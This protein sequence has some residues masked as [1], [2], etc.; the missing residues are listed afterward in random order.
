[1]SRG[2]EN[3]IRPSRNSN[4]NRYEQVKSEFLDYKSLR[5]EEHKRQLLDLNIYGPVRNDSKLFT[6]NWTEEKF[7]LSFDNIGPM[8]FHYKDKTRSQRNREKNELLQKFSL[9]FCCCLKKEKTYQNI[10]KENRISMKAHF[11]KCWMILE[12]KNSKKL[13]IGCNKNK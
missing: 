3:F 12:I 5:K 13:R 10:R 8:N 6:Q 2:V 7:N 9:M 1:M 4:L 11:G